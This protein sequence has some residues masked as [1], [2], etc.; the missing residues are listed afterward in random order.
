MFSFKHPVY[1]LQNIFASRFC[2]QLDHPDLVSGKMPQCS[3][4]ASITPDSFLNSLNHRAGLRR[5]SKSFKEGWALSN[6][7]VLRGW[8]CS[9]KGWLVSRQSWPC[10]SFSPLAEAQTYQT[11]LDPPRKNISLFWRYISATKYPRSLNTFLNKSKVPFELQ[12]SLHKTR[13]HLNRKK[14][15]RNQI[16]EKINEYVIFVFLG[17]H[18]GS[19]KPNHTKNY[20]KITFGVLFSLPPQNALQCTTVPL[21]ALTKC[22]KCEE[23]NLPFCFLAT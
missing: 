4:S 17:L 18:Y 6:H 20:Q 7:H 15:C 2:N 22:D 19:R 12:F 11:Y 10:N 16:V 1:F 21:V 13:C 5:E 23:T 8:K 9:N 3:W 14:T